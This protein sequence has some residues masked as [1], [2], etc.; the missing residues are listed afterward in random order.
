M[1]VLLLQ[2]CVLKWLPKT[3]AMNEPM[4]IMLL[5]VPELFQ[6][7]KVECLEQTECV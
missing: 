1:V 3:S 2:C 7:E 4:V 6:E 5:C